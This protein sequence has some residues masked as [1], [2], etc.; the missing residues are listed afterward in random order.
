LFRQ[1]F[2]RGN[3]GILGCIVWFIIHAMQSR[4]SGVLII[5]NSKLRLRTETA[6]L[7]RDATEKEQDVPFVFIE[8]N[9][10][11]FPKKKYA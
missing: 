11:N 10:L 8:I 5:G 4:E 9:W 1:A 6:T 3:E 2:A 7:N